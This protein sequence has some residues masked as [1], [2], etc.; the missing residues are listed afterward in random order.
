M[1]SQSESEEDNHE[2]E[3]KISNSFINQRKVTHQLELSRIL[4]QIPLLNDGLIQCPI[5]IINEIIDYLYIPF[6]VYGYAKNSL[7]NITS[8]RIF[9]YIKDQIVTKTNLMYSSPFS[10]IPIGHPNH[11][12]RTERYIYFVLGFLAP[13]R[14]NVIGRNEPSRVNEIKC[15][16][17]AN[18]TWKAIAPFNF[19]FY[20]P[21]GLIM[22]IPNENK[23]DYHHD[24]VRNHMMYLFG[25][26]YATNGHSEIKYYCEVYDCETDHWV[27]GPSFTL[28][29]VRSRVCFTNVGKTIYFFQ[30]GVRYI[31]T[32]DTSDKKAIFQSSTLENG[33]PLG[34][35]E[36]ARY[37][38][39]RLCFALDDDHII[40]IAINLYNDRTDAEPYWICQYSISKNRMI[41][42]QWQLPWNTKCGI[43][44][45]GWYDHQTNSLYV[46]GV[47]LD[48]NSNKFRLAMYVSQPRLNRKLECDKSQL[49]TKATCDDCDYWTL[50]HQG[51][52]VFEHDKS[53]DQIYFCS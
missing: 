36:E 30:Y 14:V 9:M 10:L 46:R 28:H 49:S 20:N 19:K 43:L 26:S 33:W 21:K 13:N 39:V 5:G 52:Y 35:K 45:D 7:S 4:S 37:L 11:I 48:P 41:K 18:K 34:F 29:T 15:F 50:L 23:K 22:T 17:I 8:D 24:Q 38:S 12:M 44:L 51:E 6:E 40:I 27:V 25:G 16:D 3:Q 47:V 1:S 32:L 53:D 2:N 42:L 31:Y